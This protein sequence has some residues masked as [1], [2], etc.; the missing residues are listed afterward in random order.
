[1]FKIIFL[2]IFASYGKYGIILFL[3]ENN[4]VFI[5]TEM[6]CNNASNNVLSTD[7]IKMKWPNKLFESKRN[8]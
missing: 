8:P 4:L 7:R 5:R 3:T 1:M 2:I 6:V